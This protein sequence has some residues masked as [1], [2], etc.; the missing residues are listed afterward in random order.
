V[1]P[2]SPSVFIVPLLIATVTLNVAIGAAVGELTS[3]MPPLVSLCMSGAAMGL[4]FSWILTPLRTAVY[5]RGW[6]MRPVSAP[7]EV[8]RL[9]MV[10]GAY[11]L[12]LSLYS[13][14]HIL[15]PPPV[16]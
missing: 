7:P 13:F 3:G 14:A 4:T 1:T 15:L 2:R 8:A 6:S 9:L 16:L 10:A 12:Y 5:A 11:L